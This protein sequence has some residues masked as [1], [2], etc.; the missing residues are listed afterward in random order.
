M[1]DDERQSELEDQSVDVAEQDDVADSPDHSGET[2]VVN[3]VISVN[4]PLAF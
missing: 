3:S 4:L 1:V 2:W